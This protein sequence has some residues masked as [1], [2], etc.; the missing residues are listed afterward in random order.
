M[1][2]VMIIT[3]ANLHKATKQQ[4]FNQVAT[5]LLTQKKQAKI[6]NETGTF[7]R[8]RIPNT[9]LKCAGGCIIAD[10]EYDETCETRTWHDAIKLYILDFPYCNRHENFIGNLQSIH[11]SLDPSEWKKSL[12]QLTRDEK[13]DSTCLLDFNEINK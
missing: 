5:H 9:N 12:Y 7:C 6:I 3:L 4:I 11:D 2:T 1:E 10:L 13:L 8:Y